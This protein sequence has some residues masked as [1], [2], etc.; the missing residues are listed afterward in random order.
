MEG[1]YACLEC[2]HTQALTHTDT[3]ARADTR[4]H[5]LANRASY[6]KYPHLEAHTLDPSTHTLGPYTHHRAEPNRWPNRWP[7]HRADEYANEYANQCAD[8]P[9]NECADEFANEFANGCA[10]GR[11]NHCA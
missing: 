7:N 10:N 2:P 1:L 5:T 4:P 3:L 9:A 11:T 6:H 8:A